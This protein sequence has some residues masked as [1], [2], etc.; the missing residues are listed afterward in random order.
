[1]LWPQVFGL[2]PGHGSHPAASTPGKP[3]IAVLPFTDLGQKAGQDYFA[4]G[5][6]DDLITDLSKISGLLVIARNSG[7]RFRAAAISCL[8]QQY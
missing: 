5:L 8:R 2:L 6:A 7:S 4:E 1:M 3:S